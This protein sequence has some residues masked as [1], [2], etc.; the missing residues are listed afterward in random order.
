ML[1]AQCK[2]A[3][4]RVFNTLFNNWDELSIAIG[5]FDTSPFK[6]QEFVATKIC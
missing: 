6:N 1:E 4:Q 5:W 3:K 2:S